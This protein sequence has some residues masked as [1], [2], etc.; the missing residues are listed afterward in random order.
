MF[1]YIINGITMA[2]VFN[3]LGPHNQCSC[4]CYVA[5]LYLCTGDGG[6]LLPFNIAKLHN[7]LC[8][9]AFVTSG[10]IQKYESIRKIHVLASLWAVSSYFSFSKYTPNIRLLLCLRS[11]SVCVCLDVNQGGTDRNCYSETCNLAWTDLLMNHGNQPNTR[12]GP[13]YFNCQHH[14]NVGVNQNGHFRARKA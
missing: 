12:S 1:L 3:W 14:P 2:D 11:L 13:T 9:L 5:S 10:G 8:S 4:T 7:L 6:I